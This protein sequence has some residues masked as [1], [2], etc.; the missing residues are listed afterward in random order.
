MTSDNSTGTPPAP[1]FALRPAVLNDI[2]ELVRLEMLSF[3][4]DQLTARHFHHLLTRGHSSCLVIE[5]GS[6]LVGYVLLLFRSGASLAR[7]YSLAVD[8]AWRGHGLARRLLEAAEESARDQECAF[9]R[10]EVRK[11]NQR[12][13]AIY[14]EAGYRDIGEIADYYE[15]H[16]PALRM[17]KR[18]SPA[19]RPKDAL[20][21]YYCQSSYFTCGPAALM[22][23]MKTLDPG[24]ELNRML[25]FRIWREA[26]TIFMT[27]GLGGSSPHGLALAAWYRGF[28]VDLYLNDA[29]PL[30]LDGVRDPK[31]KEVM[32]LVHQ[33]FV[34]EISHTSIRLF[35]ARLTVDD[36]QSSHAKGAIPLVLIS[37]YRIYREKNPHWIVVTGFDE[38][39]VYAHDPFVDVDEGQSITDSINL[40]ILRKEFER[41]SRYGKS[42]LR[43]AIVIRKRN[44]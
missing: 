6:A 42:Q 16:S 18:L 8:P 21:P 2:P 31:K 23:A 29:G 26:T 36:L 38:R 3:S 33:E 1:L 24:M 40:P 14:R 32:E 11:D 28:D 34:E 35:H 39:F 9:L 15:D 41:M 44:T 5:R 30:F 37:S 27:S 12:A 10:L 4:S 19:S 13:I 17:E 7:L 43:A 22:M 20:I 25:E